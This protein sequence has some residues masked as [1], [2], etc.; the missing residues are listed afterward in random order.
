[1][2]KKIVC[3][4]SSLILCLS[5]LSAK[6]FFDERYFEY[7][8][9]VP[10]SVSLTGFP[11]TDLLK[12][13]LVINLRELANTMPKNGF[14]QTLTASPSTGFNLN[15]PKFHLGFKVGTET[16]MNTTLS[17]D[18]FDFLGYGNQIGEEVNMDV[19]L[20]T[21]VFLYSTLSLGFKPKNF[22]LY[23]E[24]SM[25]IPVA[26]V[27]GS[28][29]T[30]KLLNDNQGN[31]R[32]SLS[33]MLD[34]YSIYTPGMDFSEVFSVL[35]NGM[36]FDIGGSLQKQLSQMLG[37]QVD[38][39]IPVYPGKLFSKTTYVIDFS[40]NA[41]VKN[42]SDGQTS[43]N[44][45]FITDESEFIYVTRPMYLMGYLNFSPVYL[46]DLR[47]GLGFGIRHP[48][49]QN[50]YAYFQY[51]LGASLKLG[52]IFKS[53]ISTE[54]TNQIFI[55]QLTMNF[56]FRV[57]EIDA[58]VSLQSADFAKSFSTSGLGAYVRYSIGF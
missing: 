28:A 57:M 44:I 8:V 37:M 22:T 14:T 52:G 42:F 46:I 12:D 55:N 51:Y 24:P 41:Q 36:G 30:L 15:L 32:A 45:N 19:K 17:K 16:Y 18:F 10:A 39:R 20:N 38:F 26:S 4:F 47:G 5:S 50:S 58:G 3:L 34:V 2:N 7:Y 53:T 23:L 40:Y 48:F 43:E 1:M 35:F 13:N 29:G 27:S 49:V 6:R 56:N 21:D 54:Y 33:T 31:I 25:F 9:D 11:L